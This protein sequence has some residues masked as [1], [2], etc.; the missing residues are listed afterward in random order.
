MGNT[1]DTQPCRRLRRTTYIRRPQD[2]LPIL[3]TSL[4]IVAPSSRTS[5]PYHGSP[6]R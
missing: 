5:R 3:D 2:Y 6:N 4:M 1:K